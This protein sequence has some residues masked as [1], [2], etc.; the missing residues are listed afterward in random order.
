MCSMQ[1]KKFAVGDLSPEFVYDTPFA[2]GLSFRETCAKVPGKTAL[3]FL[4]YYGCTLCQLDLHTYAAAYDRIRENGGQLLVVLQSDPKKLAQEISPE[5]FPFEIICDPKQ[6][7]YR[8]FSVGSAASMLRMM[9]A[10]SVVKAAKAMLSGYKHGAYEGDELQLPA[11]FVVQ[12]DG[13]LSYVHYGKAVGDA[14][15]PETLIAAMK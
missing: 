10:A 1:N 14:P 11:A 12:Q 2:Q 13:R 9:S 6:E 8:Q 5:T 4:R 7:L 15:A 3:V